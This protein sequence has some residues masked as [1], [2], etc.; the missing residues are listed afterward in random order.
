MP[1]K[2]LKKYLDQNKVKYRVISHSPAFTAQE[3]AATAH[4]SGKN[5]AKT[6]ILK[7]EGKLA[8]MVLPAS[9]MVNLS[10]LRET[11][12]VKQIEL[13]TEEEFKDEFPECDVGSMPPFGNLYGMEVYSSK[14]LAGDHDIAFNAGSHT[15]L[16][17]LA[18]SDFET[19]AKPRV[20]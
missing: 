17:D 20:I 14:N 2:T 10:A 13:A 16:I 6:V 11:L 9:D 18:Y 5:M 15:E 1:A 7:V 3:I 4:I 19:L 12:G 8:M